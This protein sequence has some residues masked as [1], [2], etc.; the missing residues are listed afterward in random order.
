MIRN[1]NQSEPRNKSENLNVE[2]IQLL[3]IMTQARWIYPPWT[4]GLWMI[5]TALWI[6]LLSDTFPFAVYENYNKYN[7]NYTDNII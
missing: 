1:F 3:N 4:K 2:I 5:H 7:N 6:Y